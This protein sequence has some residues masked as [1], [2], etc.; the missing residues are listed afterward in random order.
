MVS[1]MVL[2][3]ARLSWKAVRSVARVWGFVSAAVITASTAISRL[4]NSSYDVCRGKHSLLRRSA[5]AL[6]GQK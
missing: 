6:L 2:E 5:Q 3:V 1:L 4:S